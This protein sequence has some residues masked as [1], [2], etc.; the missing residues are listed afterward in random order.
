MDVYRKA[1]GC[2]I[3]A[4]VPCVWDGAAPSGPALV[5][6]YG[7]V[8]AGTTIHAPYTCWVL[9]SQRVAWLHNIAIGMNAR[10]RS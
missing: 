6:F 1:D 3:A 4:S 2:E 7:E 9:L 5:I 8:L 10:R